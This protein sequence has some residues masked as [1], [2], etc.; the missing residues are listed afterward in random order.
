MV[1]PSG[2]SRGEFFSSNSGEKMEI[3]ITTKVNMPD[4]EYWGYIDHLKKTGVAINGVKFLK[5][6][7]TVFTTKTDQ[8]NLE[9]VYEIVGHK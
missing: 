4:D 1:F 6:G 2:G 9:T 7:K 3:Q 8:M 5:E